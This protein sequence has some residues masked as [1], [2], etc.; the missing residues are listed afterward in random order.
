MVIKMGDVERCP[1][2]IPGF[3]DLCEG[4]FVRDSINA[5]L[6]GPGAGKSIFLLQFLHNGVMQYKENGLYVSFEPDMEET[7]KDGLVFG[8]DLQ[9]LDDKGYCKFLKVSPVAGIPTLKEEFTKIIARYGIKRVCFDP[10]SILGANESSEPKLRL[11]IYDLTSLLKRLG[12][13]VLLAEEIAASDGEQ[14]ITTSADVKT[15]Y[16]RFLSDSVINLYS[17]GLGGVSDRAIR[18]LKMRRTNHVHGPVP[19]EISS[20]G[21]GIASQRRARRV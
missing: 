2:G 21:I 10:V 20:S 4:G 11:L 7:Y 3:D 17:S 12:V 6:G 5:M 18:I 8:W 1:S 13:T 9:K 14:I 19:M 15:Q 16:L